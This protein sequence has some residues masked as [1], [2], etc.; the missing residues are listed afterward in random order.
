MLYILRTVDLKLA[1][2]G[3]NDYQK[4]TVACIQALAS[5]SLLNLTPDSCV[6]FICLPLAV[7]A[8]SDSG[9]GQHHH[10]IHCVQYRL[11]NKVDEG[12]EAREAS[13]ADYIG[14]VTMQGRAVQVDTSIAPNLNA[15]S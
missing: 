15:P 7:G 4:A 12:R 14:K 9:Q 6:I 1:T 5:S 8:P 13:R 10:P 11:V 2:T 3:T